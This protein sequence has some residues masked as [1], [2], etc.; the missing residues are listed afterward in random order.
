MIFL[1]NFLIDELM[2]KMIYLIILHK[3]DKL[4]IIHS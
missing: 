4:K 1:R 2:M 3:N